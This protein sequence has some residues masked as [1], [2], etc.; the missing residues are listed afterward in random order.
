MKNRGM[1]VGHQLNR[2]WTMI[3]LSIIG[4]QTDEGKLETNIFVCQSDKATALELGLLIVLQSYLKKTMNIVA[5]NT[6]SNPV[7]INQSTVSETKCV[8]TNT[9]NLSEIVKDLWD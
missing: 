5:D 3:N 6:T 8:E 2:G 4:R 7:E 1:V 9:E